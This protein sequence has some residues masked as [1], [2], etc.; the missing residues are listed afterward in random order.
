MG[1][2][3]QIRSNT[4]LFRKISDD[5]KHFMNMKNELISEV[6]EIRKRLFE[7][8]SDQ[9]IL[10]AISDPVSVLGQRTEQS[11]PDGGQK[12][13]SQGNAIQSKRRSSSFDIFQRLMQ[14]KSTEG[15]Q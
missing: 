2:T 9:K 12:S 14:T 3:E 1:I 7:Q 11:M 13:Q 6:T 5:H 10:A 8:C 4:E 15:S